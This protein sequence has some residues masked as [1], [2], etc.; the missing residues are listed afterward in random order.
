MDI[1]PECL[2]NN[3][4]KQ[5]NG[6]PRILLLIVGCLAFSTVVVPLAVAGTT[7]SVILPPVVDDEPKEKAW[8][9]KG[10]MDA[11]HKKGLLKKVATEKAT[12]DEVKQLDEMYKALGKLKPPKGQQKSWDEKTKA[13]AEASKAAVEKKEG[14]K[15]LLKNATK[16]ADCHDDHKP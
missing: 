7:P 12:V 10:I 11:A 16:C 8:T 3:V 1:R 5:L 14:F 6:R 4:S 9:I 2:S 15:S 13:L